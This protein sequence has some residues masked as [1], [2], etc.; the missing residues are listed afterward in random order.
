MIMIHLNETEI[1][2]V[3]GTNHHNFLKDDVLIIQPNFPE[4]PQSGS[5][6]GDMNTVI[7]KSEEYYLKP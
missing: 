6:S 7:K 5:L 4:T 1:V 2:P 3:P